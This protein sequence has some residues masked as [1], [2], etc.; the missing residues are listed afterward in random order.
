MGGRGIEIGA[1][2]KAMN[3]GIYSLKYKCDKGVN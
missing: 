1:R 3:S 2:N